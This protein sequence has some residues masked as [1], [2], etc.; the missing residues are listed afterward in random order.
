MLSKPSNADAKA[1]DWTALEQVRRMAETAG[2][3]LDGPS[4]RQLFELA[5]KATGGRRGP[6]L[7]QLALYGRPE[8]LTPPRG[9]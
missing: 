7:D 1:I 6:A 8:W 4:W 3:S 2:S 9:A 5:L